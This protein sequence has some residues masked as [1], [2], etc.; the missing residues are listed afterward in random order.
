MEIIPGRRVLD[1]LGN[2]IGLNVG[3]EEMAPTLAAYFDTIR[4]A[5][6]EQPAPILTLQGLLHEI[7]ARRP[8]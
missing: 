1:V 6:V 7:D 8:E 5:T 3:S 2:L 4:G